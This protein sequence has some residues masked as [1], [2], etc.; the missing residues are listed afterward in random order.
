MQ[1][2]Y[3][4]TDHLQVSFTGIPPLFTDQPYFFDVTAKF[5]LH[6]G[7]VFRS[8]VQ[9]AFDTVVSPTS[10][11]RSVFGVRAGLIGQFCLIADCLTSFT[12]NAGTLLT[13]QPNAVVP[14]YFAGGLLVHITDV[15]KLM[16]E[17]NYTAAVGNG[18][19][20]G[21]TGLLLNYGMRLSSKQFGFDLA[22]IKPL[23]SRDSGGF[24]MGIPVVSFTYRTL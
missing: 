2:G 15:F 10:N 3:A 9:V 16:V 22:F 6:R 17:P 13:D 14:V 11:P 24:V 23:G 5:N 7:D 1:V 8:A 12:L 18:K 19:V 20:D 21:P 4:V